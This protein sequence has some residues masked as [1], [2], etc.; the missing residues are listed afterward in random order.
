MRSVAALLLAAAVACVCGDEDSHTV[1]SFAT[2]GLLH[3]QAAYPCFQYQKKEP[4]TLWL[5]KI[6]PYHNPMETY[7]FYDLPFCAP[8]KQLQPRSKFAGFGEIL[9]G[10]EYVNSDLPIKFNGK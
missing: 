10:V 4:V 7:S 1:R 5:N 9:E 6:G 2:R 8:E 3:A